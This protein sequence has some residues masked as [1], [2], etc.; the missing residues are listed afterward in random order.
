MVALMT[1]HALGLIVVVEGV[2]ALA[3]VIFS[4][5]RQALA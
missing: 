2:G 4:L 3:A 5:D 1:R